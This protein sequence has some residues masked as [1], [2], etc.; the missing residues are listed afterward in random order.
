MVPRKFYVRSPEIVAKDLLGK[1]LVRDLE[2]ERL[3]G[4]I[5][6]TE[7]YLGLTDPASHAFRGRTA[8]N[9]VLFG[10]PGFTH[11]Y[12][13]YGLHDCLS[14][15]CLPEGEAGGVLLRALEPIAGL[16]IMVRMRGLAGNPSAKALTGGPGRLGQ[17]LGINRR[18]H[19]GVDV[20]NR[21]SPIQILDD[22]N[23][24]LEVGITPRIGISKAIERPLRFVALSR[25]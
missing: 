11:V 19:N 5:V 10:P 9:A 25:F 16:D 15:S 6:E 22:G 8:A 14:I 21:K 12:L 7:A 17:A 1:L 4:R 23:R 20:T 13:I 3:V 24:P 2:G 18:Q